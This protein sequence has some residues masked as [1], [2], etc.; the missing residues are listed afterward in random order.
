[1]ICVTGGIIVV[2]PGC[3]SFVCVCDRFVLGCG[4]WAVAGPASG[5]W[6]GKPVVL[7]GRPGAPVKGCGGLVGA[8]YPG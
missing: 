3:G 8:G 1:M 4:G 6:W 5:R 7:L 2:V